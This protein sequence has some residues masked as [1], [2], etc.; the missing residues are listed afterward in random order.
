MISDIKFPKSRHKSG[1][2]LRA[3]QAANG[4][5]SSHEDIKV[6]EHAQSGHA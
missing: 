2:S 5:S 4:W 6:D 1:L 3:A